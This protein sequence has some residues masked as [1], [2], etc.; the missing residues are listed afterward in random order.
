MTREK[1]LDISNR[2]LDVATKFQK[3]PIIKQVGR[4]MSHP[5]SLVYVD[6]D[7]K[8]IKDLKSLD[9]AV[10]ELRDRKLPV[11]EGDPK[12]GFMSAVFRRLM[13]KS[14]VVGAG[15]RELADLAGDY[16][17]AKLAAAFT[18]DGVTRAGALPEG[19]RGHGLMDANGELF[20]TLRLRKGPNRF[21]VGMV[22]LQGDMAIV[23]NSL[24]VIDD[25]LEIAGRT[26]L[27]HMEKFGPIA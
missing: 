21:G 12:A 24:S 14:V 1:R 23:P 8:K 17:E 9:L 20:A 5:R 4:A 22:L 13:K 2:M 6:V 19:Y 7:Y 3:L 26:E 15:V 10:K 25:N 27:V 18:Y 16:P 11:V